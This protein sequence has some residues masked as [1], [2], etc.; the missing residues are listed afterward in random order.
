MRDMISCEEVFEADPQARAEF[1]AVCDEWQN[2]AILAQDEDLVECAG[3]GE[4]WFRPEGHTGD[5]IDWCRKLIAH[6]SV[7]MT[8]NMALIEEVKA[9]TRI[10]MHPVNHWMVATA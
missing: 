1:D 4:Q 8:P 2:E 9:F 6:P 10:S 5:T 7:S 3:C